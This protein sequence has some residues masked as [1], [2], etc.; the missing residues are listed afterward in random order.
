MHAFMHVCMHIRM[1]VCMH[2]C[3]YMHMYAC[4]YVRNGMYKGS[5][6]MLSVYIHAC[7]NVS[8]ICITNLVTILCSQR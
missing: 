2:V 3:M 1:Y 8:I 6:C 7:Y 5:Y 4:M